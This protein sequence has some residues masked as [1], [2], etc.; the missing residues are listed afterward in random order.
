MLVSLQCWCHLVS[1]WCLVSVR[2]WCWGHSS[3]TLVLVSHQ[4]HSG[5]GA[6]VGVN[7]VLV[8]LQCHTGVTPVLVSF[9][10]SYPCHSSAD[11][12]PVSLWWCH[13]SVIEVFKP[14]INYVYS[15]ILAQSHLGYLQNNMFNCYVVI[16]SLGNL[17]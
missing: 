17:V 16:P 8:S 5:A 3:V 11:V 4:C 13:T 15:K 1:L 6:C 9:M 14:T 7:L 2:C 12:T 10:V